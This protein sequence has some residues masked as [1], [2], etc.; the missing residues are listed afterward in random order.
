MTNNEIVLETFDAMG[1]SVQHNKALM[2]GISKRLAVSEALA[3]Q[4]IEIAIDEGKLT[5]DSIGQVRR[6]HQ[7]TCDSE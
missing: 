7:S 2:F 6:A 3:I 4:L 5:I 1:G